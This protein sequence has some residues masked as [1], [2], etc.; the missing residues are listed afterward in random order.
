MVSPSLS[1][2]ARRLLLLGGASL[3]GPR[4]IP[5]LEKKTAAL[6]TYLA[7]EGPTSRSRIA[8]LLW[9][10]SKESTA[11]NNLAQ[12]IRRLRQGS[13]AAIVDGETAVELRDVTTDAGDLLR[14]VEQ[15]AFE[16]AARLGW[17]L[18]SGFDLDECADFDVWLR[19]ARGR[20]KLSWIRAAEEEIQRA[21]R[22]GDLAQASGWA[23]RIVE[24]EPLSEAAYLRVARIHLERGDASAAM[25][26][27]DTCKRTLARELGMKP[28]AAMLEVYR[29]IR[30][31]KPRTPARNAGQDPLPVQVL[32]PKWVGRA[33]EW[34]RLEAVYEAREIA[35]IEGEAGVGKSRL[36]RDFAAKK[37]LVLLVEGR[38][39]D[40][41]VPFSTLARSLRTLALAQ[42]RELP[43]WARAELARVVPELLEDDEVGVTSTRSKL[44]FFEAVAHVLAMVA[45]ARDISLVLDDLQWFDGASAEV[46]LWIADRAARRELA[47]HVFA[48]H[49]AGELPEDIVAILGRAD[50]SG[51]VHFMRV[52][53]LGPAE[54]TELVESLGLPM[55]NGR[56]RSIAE[57]C[58]GVPLYAL[59]IVRSIVDANAPLDG[60]QVAL[61]DR[62]R[63]LLRRRLDRLGESARRL[64]RV[65][66]V[67]GPEFDLELAAF[68]LDVS[69]FDLIEPL[70]ELE[71]A[72]VIAGKRFAHDLLADAVREALPEALREHI[73]S[74]TADHL[75]KS[76]VDPARIAQHLEAA[77]RGAEAAPFLVRAGN[78]ARGLSRIADGIALYDRA[79]RLFEAA[80]DLKS[81]SQALYLRSRSLMG[82]EA[83]DVVARLE[84]FAR[85]DAERARAL[86]TR[87]NVALEAGDLEQAR[88][89]GKRAYPLA[90]AA[91]DALVAA[92]SVQA[93]L[94]ADLRSG[95]IEDAEQA[96]RVFKEAS[97]AL[98]EDPEAVAAILYYE[99]DLAAL[100]DDHHA[101]IAKFEETLAFLDRWGQL[102]HGQGGIYSHLTGS[103]LAIGRVEDAARCIERAEQCLES[104][105]GATQAYAHF[106]LARGVLL[107]RRGDLQGAVAAVE[108]VREHAEHRMVLAARQLAAEVR[109]ELGSLDDAELELTTIAEDPRGNARTRAAAALAQARIA[110]LR[111]T[112]IP[113]TVVRTIE[114][115]GGPVQIATLRCLQAS[116]VDA[117]GADAL[118]EAAAR[119]ARDLRLPPL[120]A[121]VQ[122]SRERLL[123]LR[124]DAPKG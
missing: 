96:L 118:L 81:A 26:I 95:R 124:P 2:G 82:P 6:V 8:G 10:E 27:Y 30:D 3:V 113:A 17:D 108:L 75:A 122:A 53:P 79:A 35:V 39:G 4:A 63:G 72:Q 49:R 31:G 7:L 121:D 50:S 60:A 98:S 87:A 86:C 85:T 14:F 13:G 106:H 19:G 20:T 84:R 59:E 24:A 46:L 66:S 25:A 33:N 123:A 99:A 28:S 64:A 57:A 70:T 97:D 45:A 62:V 38:P 93:W 40:P 29:T 47:L 105:I 12:A 115:L 54:M 48:A 73:H 83:A 107:Q 88:E 42:R 69:A 103:Y 15:G 21:E 23:A 58:R 11:R 120:E 111:S 18:L 119:T 61:P 94:D 80:G 90:L 76:A 71:R 5:R 55:L 100:R 32:R 117:I 104:T 56:A 51:Q 92:E 67:A 114:D 116:E 91:G 9:P 16:R 44:R 89:A 68:V 52:E 36:V 41:D 74:K 65:M 101:A 110:R 102:L 109:V 22:S 78:A 34:A 43:P 112:P 37:G 77:G 1:D